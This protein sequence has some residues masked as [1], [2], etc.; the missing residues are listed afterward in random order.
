MKNRP[1]SKM[2]ITKGRL[3]VCG[4]ARGKLRNVVAER[5]RVFEAMSSRTKNSPARDEKV[6]ELMGKKGSD[7]DSTTFLPSRDQKV[8]S[9]YWARDTQGGGTEKKGLGIRYKKGGLGEHV[10]HEGGVCSKCGGGGSNRER[11]RRDRV[12]RP[13][14]RGSPPAGA[15]KSPPVFLKPT[16]QDRA[17]KKKESFMFYEKPS[18]RDANTARKEGLW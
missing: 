9:C 2:S 14:S 6:G 11:K 7:K 8:P 5:C 10:E 15:S 4:K 18:S 16:N 13:R 12:T 3:F 1:R 17:E